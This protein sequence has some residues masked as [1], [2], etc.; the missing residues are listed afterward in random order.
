LFLQDNNFRFAVSSQF[1]AR[2]CRIIWIS[3]LVMV[4]CVSYL[5]VVDRYSCMF[6][7]Y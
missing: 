7:C 4:Y 1:G 2:Y 6:S 3:W 5:L